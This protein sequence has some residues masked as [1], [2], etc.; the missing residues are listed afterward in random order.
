MSVA[1]LVSEIEAATA[2]L[3]EKGFKQGL[4]GLVPH[5]FLE[6]GYMVFKTQLVQFAADLCASE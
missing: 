6:G 1:D 3:D 2:S 5:N 4:F